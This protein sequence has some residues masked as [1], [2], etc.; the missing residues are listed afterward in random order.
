MLSVFWTKYQGGSLK[1]L[2][3]GYTFWKK[4][5]K[6]RRRPCS[7]SDCS[8]SGVWGWAQGDSGMAEDANCSHN[9]APATSLCI[10][11]V[12]PG[13]GFKMSNDHQASRVGAPT[14]RHWSPWGHTG[15]HPVP[16]VQTSEVDST[17]LMST[18]G[19]SSREQNSCPHLCKS[20][21]T[22]MMLL[23]LWWKWRKEWKALTTPVHFI[24]LY[25]GNIVCIGFSEDVFLYWVWSSW[26]NHWNF[27][28]RAINQRA[29]C[30]SGFHT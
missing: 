22:V 23:M 27:L 14:S 28:K 5:E 19:Q 1:F 21:V 8:S 10:L 4:N 30:L 16:Q 9:D 26:V 29:A 13:Q 7:T 3:G 2:N 24:F 18:P 20:M 11:S 12:L 6:P 15:D 25:D 17:Q